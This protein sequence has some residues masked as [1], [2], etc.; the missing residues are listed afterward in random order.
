MRQKKSFFTK[1]NRL[2]KVG[3]VKFE[4]NK[5]AEEKILDPET[6]ADFERISPG[7]SEKLLILAKS[8]Q[9]HSQ[10]MDHIQNSIAKTAYRM[11]HFSFVFIFIAICYFTYSLIL[12][13]MANEGLVFGVLAFI[14]LIVTNCRSKNKSCSIKEDEKQEQRMTQPYRK[15]HQRR[16]NFKRK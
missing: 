1:N 13:N 11:G 7:F 16:R 9:S 15:P 6:L 8:E 10:K 3:A 2:D 14:A 5:N 12:N 4:E